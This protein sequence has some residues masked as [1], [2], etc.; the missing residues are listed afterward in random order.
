MAGTFSI[1]WL[2]G[3]VLLQRR[4]GLFTVDEAN[5]YVAA[6]KDAVK[7]APSR[8]GAVIDTRHA[9]AQTEEVQAIIQDLIQYVVGKGVKRV[10]IVSTSTITGLQEKRITTAPGMHDPSTIAFFSD[11]DVAVTDVRAAVL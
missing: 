6:V 3:N 2:P 9:V 1:E 5:K 10:V 11:Y 8:W 4:T 7:K